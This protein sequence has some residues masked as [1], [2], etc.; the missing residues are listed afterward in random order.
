MRSMLGLV[1][2]RP[3]HYLRAKPGRRT[4]LLGR[5]WETEAHSI[6]SH[7]RTP[8]TW[9]PPHGVGG[10]LNFKRLRENSKT[11]PFTA[12]SV[13]SPPE[14]RSPPLR[15]PTLRPDASLR[16]PC[17][18]SGGCALDAFGVSPSLTGCR[19]FT[20]QQLGKLHKLAFGT[21]AHDEPCAPECDGRKSF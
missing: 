19:H 6:R 21:G 2:L 14:S 8:I 13:P 20:G 18:R 16:T 15:S 10:M 7:T 12:H 4:R 1:A 11:R 5:V 9:P 17:G 3:A